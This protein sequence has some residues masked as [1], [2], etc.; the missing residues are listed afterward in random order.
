MQIPLQQY[1]NVLQLW[2]FW[3]GG[4][5]LFTK[6]FFLRAGSCAPIILWASW[7]DRNKK[8]QSP[9]FGSNLWMEWI[10]ERHFAKAAKSSNVAGNV[11]SSVEQLHSQRLLENKDKWSLS[12]LEVLIFSLSPSL[13]FPWNVKKCA[14]FVRVLLVVL[15]SAWKSADVGILFLFSS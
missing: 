15:I 12:A 7:D 4:W 2:H 14:H 11:P 6:A 13:L 10:Q 8:G 9:L 3:S 1:W 5:K